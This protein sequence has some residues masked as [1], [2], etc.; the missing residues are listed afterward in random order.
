MTSIENPD[1]AFSKM[2]DIKNIRIFKEHFY[3]C[4]SFVLSPVSFE[5][6]ILEAS[7]QKKEDDFFDPSFFI[8]KK[9]YK[10]QMEVLDVENIL[11]IYN[12]LLLSYSLQN[13]NTYIFKFIL[14]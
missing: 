3:C 8:E 11:Q 12:G 14:N 1:M 2:T 4:F 13:S 5:D 7:Y 6:N 10:V 9:S